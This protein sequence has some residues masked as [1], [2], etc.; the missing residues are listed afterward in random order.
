[1]KS[2]FQLIILGLIATLATVLFISI[3][4]EYAASANSDASPAY[5]SKVTR[6][7]DGDTLEVQAMIWPKIVVSVSVR[8]A[9]VDTPETFQPKC[10]E[11]K[12]L[13]MKA[14]E[15]VQ[16]LFPPG[17]VALLRNVAE[18]KYSGRVIAKVYTT[19]GTDLAELLITHG[20]A[21]PYFG[22]TKSNWCNQ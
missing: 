10:P 11:E 21:K 16:K 18:D 9:G 8:V 17:S 4:P 15:L 5:M 1:M 19:D 14:K 7:I 6:V 12:A 20:L 22:K 13:G 2:I 3:P